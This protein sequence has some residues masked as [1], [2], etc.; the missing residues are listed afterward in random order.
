M[1]HSAKGFLAAVALIFLAAPAGWTEVLLLKSGKKVEAKIVERTDTCVKVD[2]EGVPLT[3]FSD[4]IESIDGQ[5][6]RSGAPAETPAPAQKA[7]PEEGAAPPAEPPS[8]AFVHLVS[9]EI[10]KGNVAKQSDGSVIIEK[11]GSRISYKAEDILKIE[12]SLSPAVVSS[13]NEPPFQTAVITYSFTGDR[14]G[15]Q[16]VYIDRKRNKVSKE[17]WETV[18]PM[19]RTQKIHEIEIYDGRKR[20]TIMQ[21]LSISELNTNEAVG[22]NVEGDIL[23]IMFDEGRFKKYSVS[24]GKVLDKECIVYN[25]LEGQKLY[26]WNGI[27]L[28]DEVSS[29]QAGMKIDYTIVATGIQIDVP[30]PDDVFQLPSG[31]KVITPAE[32]YIKAMAK[33]RGMVGKSGCPVKQ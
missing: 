4:E 5:A 17:K 10:I 18:S 20:F 1:S 14:T 21:N 28:K 24:K 33:L 6:L 30:I 31:V 25:A 15:S 19:G 8:E 29:H 23:G 22:E 16:T 2:L 3:Y 26:F 12:D 7:A 13:G 32:A 11:Q 9:G 27:L